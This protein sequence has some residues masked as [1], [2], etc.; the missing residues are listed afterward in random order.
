MIKVRNTNH[1]TEFLTDA[2]LR[3]EI[4]KCEYCSEK[5]CKEACPV[6]CSPADFIMAVKVGARSDFKRAAAHIMGSNPL[7]GVCGAVCPDTHCMKACVHRTFNSAV[8]IPDVQATIIERA[9][10]LDA[11]PEFVLTKSNGKKV[12]VFGAGPTGLGAAALLAQKGYAV[13]IFDKTKQPGGMCNLI[14]KSRLSQKVLQSD[15]DFLMSLGKISL[16]SG[17]WSSAIKNGYNA[18]LIATGLDEPFI[19]SITGSNS[20]IDWITYLGNT[21][22]YRIKGKRIAIVGGVCEER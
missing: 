1:T 7:G 19:P 6:D 8:N 5:P 18:R 9:K 4:E 10:A 2:Q 16:K 21:K 17:K 12:A 22:R 3:A 11:M 20:A 13:D 15:I 14:P